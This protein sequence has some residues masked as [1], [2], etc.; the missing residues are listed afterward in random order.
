[1]ERVER[2]LSLLRRRIALSCRLSWFTK[3]FRLYQQRYEYKA[4]PNTC[5]VSWICVRILIADWCP[6]A[7][8][9]C[10]KADP[11]LYSISMHALR[12]LL[13][14]GFESLLAIALYHDDGEEAAD[15]GRAEDDEDDRDAD[16][17]DAWEEEGVEEVVIVD[18]WLCKLVTKLGR[19]HAGPQRGHVQTGGRVP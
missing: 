7:P 3:A 6:R 12:C 1:V 10:P 5:I 18:E 19:K 16:G 4:T 2:V 13:L 15:D 8:S 9:D 11:F 17:P 14:L